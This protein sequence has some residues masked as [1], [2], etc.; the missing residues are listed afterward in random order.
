MRTSV[1]NLPA[2]QYVMRLVASGP[3]GTVSTSRSFDV[4][5]S[6]VTWKKSRRDLD[7]EAE[8]VLTEEQYAEY[9]QL[10]LGEK[11]R[12]MQ[13]YWRAHDPTPDT[14]HNEMLAEFHRRVAYADLNYSE[15]GRGALSDRGKVYVRFG[16]PTE[17]QAE[18]M[19]RH[20]AGRGA[21]QALEKIDNAYVASEHQPSEEKPDDP[22]IVGTIRENMPY[23]QSVREQ[24]RARVIGPGNEVVAYELWL[25]SGA[26]SPLTPEDRNVAVDSGLRLLFLDLEGFGRYR[27]RKSSARLDIHGLSVH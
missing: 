24:E 17:V 8:I 23:E 18:A 3:Q 13:D 27:L 12:Y 26:G 16:P 21:E 5:W 1:N 19:P 14:A 15:S 9:R 11:E 25:Y 2:G 22:E 6:L 4:A 20:L 7:L 10:P